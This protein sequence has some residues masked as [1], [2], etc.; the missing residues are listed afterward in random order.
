MFSIGWLDFFQNVLLSTTFWVF[1]KWSYHLQQICQ[2]TLSSPTKKLVLCRTGQYEEKWAK[3]LSLRND[4]FVLKK[5]GSQLLRSQR[6]DHV[7]CT[8]LVKILCVPLKT[9]LWRLSYSPTWIECMPTFYF[10][11]K[12][13]FFFSRICNFS[14]LSC[15]EEM[16]L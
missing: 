9:V 7:A 8:T 14:N 13:M 11:W 10:P 12:R 2:N 3:I 15:V 5:F 4:P 1:G 16:I 6:K